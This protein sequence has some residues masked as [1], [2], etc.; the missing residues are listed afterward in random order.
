MS[1][2]RMVGGTPGTTPSGK[3]TTSTSPDRLPLMVGTGWSGSNL[4][5]DGETASAGASRLSPPST[6]RQ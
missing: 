6:V 3:D 2:R 5:L 4:Y 1:R